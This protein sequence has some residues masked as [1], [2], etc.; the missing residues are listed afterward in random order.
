LKEVVN[1]LAE[2]DLEG[3]GDERVA[4]IESVEVG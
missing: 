2:A 4:D 3:V 1:A